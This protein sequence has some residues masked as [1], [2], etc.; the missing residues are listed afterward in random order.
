MTVAREESARTAATAHWCGH[1][2]RDRR[3]PEVPCPY[4][5]ALMSARRKQCGAEECHLR[6]HADR[7]K[8]HTANWVK[9]HPEQRK[10][11]R[12]QRKALEKG[13]RT[14]KK[15]VPCEIFER[16]DWR[17]G[18]CGGDVPQDARFPDPLSATIDHIIPLSC[19]GQHTEAN[20]Q[21]AHLTCNCSVRDKG[22]TT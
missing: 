7:A 1:Q 10:A 2:K 11:R 22:G 18:L 17:C 3:M 4:C 16:D 19:G 9:K 6:Y 8:K 12:L 15:I 20:V 14:A 21:L 5:G 13:A